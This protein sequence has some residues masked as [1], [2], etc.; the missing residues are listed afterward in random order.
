M[1]KSV[2]WSDSVTTSVREVA[3]PGRRKRWDDVSW[4]DVNLTGPKNKKNSQVDS[5]GTN[6]R[7]KFKIAMS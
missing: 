1:K 6:G 5:A 3:A 7:W 2:T 4:I